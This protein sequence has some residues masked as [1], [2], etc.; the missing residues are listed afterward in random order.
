MSRVIRFVTPDWEHPKNPSTGKYIPLRD[1]N[2]F[3]SDLND[4]EKERAFF[5]RK[6]A[7]CSFRDWYGEKP[8]K[9]EY[10]PL[11]AKEE[12]THMQMYEDTSLGTPISPVF[13]IKEKEAL[14]AWL[15][16]NGVP[17]YGDRLISKEQ[18]EEVIEDEASLPV[19]WSVRDGL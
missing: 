19:I 7:G 4:Y 10:T 1:G 15:A 18:W 2:S 9:R 11:W 17:Y 6:K 12:I 3:K 13:P 8:V 5:D 16:E 14:A